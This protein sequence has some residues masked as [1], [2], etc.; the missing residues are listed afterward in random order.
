MALATFSTAYNVVLYV[1]YNPSFSNAIKDVL[2]F[3]YIKKKLG[4]SHSGQSMHM[5]PETRSEL[6]PVS[7]VCSDNIGQHLHGDIC[8]PFPHK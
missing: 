8:K 2:R 3:K 5:K 6:L 7:T 4:H 1:V